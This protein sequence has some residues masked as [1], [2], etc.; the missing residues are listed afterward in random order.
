MAILIFIGVFILTFFIFVLKNREKRG[1]REAYLKASLTIGFMVVVSTELMSAFTV[2]SY[3]YVLGFWTIAFATTA[4]ITILLLVANHKKGTLTDL[5][6]SN[7]YLKHKNI[8]PAEGISVIGVFAI[9]VITLVTALVSPPN[10]MDSMSYHMPRVMHWIQNA[11]ISH[12]PTDNVRQISFPPAAG[13]TIAHFVILSGNDYFVNGVQWLAYL[14]SILGASLI[15]GRFADRK[16]QIMSALFCATLP[17]AILQSATTQ[18][19][20]SVAFCLVCSVYFILRTKKYSSSDLV[21]VTLSFSL[22][23]MT[24][25]T[26]YFFGFPLGILLAIRYASSL[27]AHHS[28]F[29]VA[30]KVTVLVCCV[31]VGA[32]LLSAANY[33]R[34]QHTFGSF[35]GPDGG[36]RCEVIGIKPLASNLTRSMALSLP[37]P[38]YWGWVS[39][40]HEKVLDF[41]VDDERTTFHGNKF[42]KCPEWLFLLPDEDFVGNP[43][44]LLLI[45][46]TTIVVI[47]RKSI[48]EQPPPNEMLWLI[49]AV[50]GGVLTLNLLIKWQIW[51][52]RLHLTAFILLAPVAGSMLAMLRRSLLIALVAA[53]LLQ[54][55][56]YS[57]ISVRHPLISLKRFNSPIFRSSS[58]FQVPRENL[59]FN[60]NF[61]YMKA[62]ISELSNR[63]QSDACRFLGITLARPEFEY[64]VW[65]LLNRKNRDGVKIK[66]LRVENPSKALR[67]EFSDSVMCATAAIDMS[68]ITYT[69]LD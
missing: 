30:A 12:Y 3:N 7:F 16:G 14:G 44:H 43:V 42:S 63:L 56:F 40:V 64:P 9:L 4:S 13:Y 35:L 32:F 23:I 53:L 36:T 22:A 62:P 69:T 25:P 54:G 33:W 28:Y 1:I 66:H 59:Y 6:R 15:A 19:D 34:N 37:L 27:K 58:I 31:G 41:D 38:D 47:V 39:A 10:N 11:S 52:N 55:A 5:F 46:F 67:Q 65:A 60:G 2:F 48:R 26:A 24:K 57:L 45:I 8:G 51:G 21:W 61:E 29:T 68:G 20:L 49:F 50:V 17:M 18:T